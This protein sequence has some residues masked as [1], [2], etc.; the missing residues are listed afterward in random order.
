MI[1]FRFPPHGGIGI[2]RTAYCS[3]YL[4]E[5][6]WS[7]H[8]LTGPLG[9][10][11]SLMDESQLQLIPEHVPVKR[12]GYFD[13]KRVF[14]TLGKFHLASLARTLTAS[15]PVMNAG[16]IPYACRA[17]RQLLRAGG[18]DLIYSSSYPVACHM[19]AYRLKRQTGVPWVADYRDE[20]STRG[21]L[22]WQ[23]SWHRRLAFRLDRLTTASADRVVTTSPAAAD[24]LALRFPNPEPGHYVTVTNGFDEADFDKSDG[25]PVEVARSDRFHLGYVG[26]LYRSKRLNGVLAAVQALV[27]GGRIPEDQIAVSIVGPGSDA[28]D[29]P[30]LRE[31]GILRTVGFVS[32]SE[33]VAW[34]AGSDALLLPNN[35]SFNIPGKTFEYLATG[36]PILA[37][38][39]GGPT[40]D[41]IRE[42]RAGVTVEP[43]DADG[44]A[45]EIHRM[46]EAWKRGHL[47]S[48]L[49]RSVLR[50]YT[51]RETVRRLAE[52]FDDTVARA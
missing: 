22:R 47:Q 25:L 33:A 50:R 49:D 19:V 9:N 7:P 23:S 6:G 43:G 30:R 4:E 42:A 35:E 38:L 24:R 32:H 46:Y 20:W 16:W 41:I 17:G 28:H 14:Q 34:M 45:R 27:D 48:D 18:F 40:A 29:F 10:T 44:I 21:T 8:I 13:T 12:T 39:P 31:A 11:H 5:H 2:R 36:N 51:W 15:L 26:T 37:M 1:A 52:I 3:R